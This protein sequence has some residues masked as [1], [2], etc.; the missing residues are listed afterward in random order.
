M[1]VQPGCGQEGCHVR[2]L[3]AVQKMSVEQC[4]QYL[5][6]KTQLTS[7]RFLLS[8]FFFCNDNVTVAELHSAHQQFPHPSCLQQVEN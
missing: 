3:R 5:R 8:P 2:P 6:C 1:A 4:L 7:S